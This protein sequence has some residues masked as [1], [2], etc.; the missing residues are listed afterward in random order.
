M[1]QVAMRK[2][3]RAMTDR[4]LA[5]IGI[6]IFIA[7]AAFSALALPAGADTAS[8]IACKD[9][10]IWDEGQKKCVPIPRGSHDGSIVGN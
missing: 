7:Y 1:F 5:L 9:G 10:E 6:G 3:R 4:F 2:A 8:A